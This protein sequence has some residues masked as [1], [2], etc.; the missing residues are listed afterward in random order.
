[1]KTVFFYYNTV[2]KSLYWEDESIIF[3]DHRGWLVLENG[4]RKL[5]SLEDVPEQ[6]LSLDGV[7]IPYIIASLRS[8]GPIWARWCGKGDQQELKL[9][10]AQ[11]LVLRIATGL[12][13]LNVRCCVMHTGVSHHVDSILFEIACQMVKLPLLFLYCEVFSTRLIPMLQVGNIKKR[14]SLGVKIS[15]YVY[16]GIINEFIANKKRELP[17]ILNTEVTRFATTWQLAIPILLWQDIK[18]QLKLLVPSRLKTHLVESNLFSFADESYPFQ[19]TMQAF[20]QRIAMQYLHSK[21]KPAQYYLNQFASDHSPKLMIVAH[22]QPEATSFPEGGMWGNHIDIALELIR[23]GFK[24]DLVYKEHPASSMY[25]MTGGLAGSPT[26]VGMSRSREYYRQLEAIGCQFVNT[27]YKLSID[28]SKCYWY[29]PVTITGTIA[30]ERA[31]AGLHTVVAGQPWFKDMPGI[32]QMDD[33]VSFAEI[34]EEWITPDL[35]LARSAFDFLTE[36]L[37]KKTINNAP[38]IGSAI[39]KTDKESIEAFTK[40]FSAALQ[41]LRSY[42]SAADVEN[43]V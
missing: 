10:Q 42:A 18:Q 41:G 19:L 27:E 36:I 3:F 4:V 25:L 43:Y 24:G 34:R 13:K 8:W 9:R 21:T 22:Y 23:K 16:E 39:I 7:D 26:R 17:P 30:I 2:L 6:N 20:Q 1:M 29:L 12:K 14:H 28:P 31:L 40:E 15:D 5:C 32:L 37:D 33:L 38:G 35:N 11:M